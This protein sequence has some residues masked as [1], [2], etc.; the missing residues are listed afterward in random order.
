MGSFLLSFESFKISMLI[1][2]S[3]VQLQEL[4]IWSKGGAGTVS[5]K[6]F[7]VLEPSCVAYSI[8]KTRIESFPGSHT[9][10]YILVFIL[11]YTF[12]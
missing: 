7:S 6:F 11:S 12:V 5:E 9:S 2:P 8:S 3:T 4:G 1:Y 10:Q